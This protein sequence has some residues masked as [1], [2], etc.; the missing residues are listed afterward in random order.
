[1]RQR[2]Q[3]RCRSSQTTTGYLTGAVTAALMVWTS[4]SSIA[5][6]NI[7]VGI[8]DVGNLTVTERTNITVNMKLLWRDSSVYRVVI[9]IG[10]MLVR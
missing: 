4:T 6:F 5:Q 2:N 1:M 7:I 9:S 3:S 8:L 10:M